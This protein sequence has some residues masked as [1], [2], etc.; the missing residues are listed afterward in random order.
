MNL[1]S[2]QENRFQVSFSSLKNVVFSCTS[3][4]LPSISSS[5]ELKIPYPMADMNLN[6][7]KASYGSL[8]LT[9]IVQEDMKNYIELMAWM[10]SIYSP[11][12]YEEFGKFRPNPVS[13]STKH[14]KSDASI[15]IM[16]NSMIKIP[17]LEIVVR[18][19]FPLSVGGLTFQTTT[20]NSQL[21]CNASFSILNFDFNSLEG[22]V[23]S[24]FKAND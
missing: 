12:S 19:C 13:Y 7:S 22:K 10:R 8:D 23:E 2:L 21:T 1:N 11:N 4:T 9:F 20:E 15:L 18:D 3:L 16:N 14:Q 6:G 17:T 5:T 24:N